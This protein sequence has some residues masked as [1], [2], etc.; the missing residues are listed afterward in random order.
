MHQLIEQHYPGLKLGITEWNWGAE[1]HIS[2]GLAVADVLG[3][4]GR[5]G[6]YL[7]N[8]W[9]HPPAGSPAYQAFKLYTNYD[10]AGGRFG[11]SSVAAASSAESL[12]AYAATDTASGELTLMLVNK[13]LANAQP[14]TL[15]LRN[16]ATSGAA[17]RY[18]F[19]QAAPGAI[20]E[21]PFALPAGSATLLVIAGP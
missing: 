12:S 20:A 18:S 1:E 16:L 7:A 19:S 11:D 8:Y 5:E 9:T 13:D 14:V 17:T 21:E 6:V 15:D 10:G 4:F 3:I 2:G